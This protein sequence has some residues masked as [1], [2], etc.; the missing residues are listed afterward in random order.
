MPTPSPEIMELSLAVVGVW[1]VA[2]IFRL[3]VKQ[4]AYRRT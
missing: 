1:V 3:I 4:I 2:W